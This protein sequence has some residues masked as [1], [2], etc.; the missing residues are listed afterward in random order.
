M[1]MSISRGVNQENSLY[2]NIVNVAGWNL[3]IRVF[4]RERLVLS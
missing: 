1:L 4:Y 3:G 2:S